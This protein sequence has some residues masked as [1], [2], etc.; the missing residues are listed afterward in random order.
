[1]LKDLPPVVPALSVEIAF[2][3]DVGNCLRDH[4][5]VIVAGLFFVGY[6]FRGDARPSLIVGDRDPGSTRGLTWSFASQAKKAPSAPFSS[7]AKEG[8]RT[9]AICSRLSPL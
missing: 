4:R 6:H 8:Q 7:F 2:S 9:T 5:A 3:L 1:V